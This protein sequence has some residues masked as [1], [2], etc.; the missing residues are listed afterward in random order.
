MFGRQS[1]FRGWDLKHT[2]QSAGFFDSLD[3]MLQIP[4]E[5][6]PQTHH[7]NTDQFQPGSQNV[8]EST[9]FGATF[10]LLP[11]GAL[12][13]TPE[14]EIT[15]AN[16]QVLGMLNEIEEQLLGQAFTALISESDPHYGSELCDIFI[17]DLTANLLMTLIGTRHENVF[18]SVNARRLYCEETLTNAGYLLTIQEF[19]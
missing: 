10:D 7:T 12:F 4:G 5:T 15:R 11:E 18:V 3:D 1:Q 14:G 9:L 2:E 13:L 16:Y 17:K 19:V 6:S 8:L